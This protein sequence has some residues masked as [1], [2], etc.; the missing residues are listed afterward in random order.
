MNSFGISNIN[1]IKKGQFWELTRKQFD[2]LLYKYPMIKFLAPLY[3]EANN[4]SSAMV[5]RYMLSNAYLFEADLLISNPKIIKKYHYRSDFLSIEKAELKVLP[6]FILFR[7][8]FE[9]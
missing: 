9:E 1:Y 8:F 5:A 2:Q 4:I 7:T 6:S 3:N